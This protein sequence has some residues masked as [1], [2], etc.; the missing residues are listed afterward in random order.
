[1]NFNIIAEKYE[2]ISSIQTNASG[3]LFNLL[4][5]KASESVLDVGCGPGNLT[6]KIN[7]ITGVKVMGI[8]PSASMIEEAKKAA[9]GKDIFFEIKTAEDMDY[10]NQFDVIFCNSAF[11]WFKKPDNALKKFYTA[12]KANGRAG[13]QAPARQD[14]CPNFVMAID[15]IKNNEKTKDV[16]THFKSPWTFYET[17]DDYKKMFE[18]AGFDVAFAKIK[19]ETSMNSPD[20]VYEIFSSGAIAGY[21]NPENYGINISNEYIKNFNDIIKCSFKDQSDKNGTVELKFNRIYL[22]ALKRGTA[23]NP[24]QFKRRKA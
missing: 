5:I 17:A 20:K 12:L 4:D 16:F 10:E 6:R 8:D 23:P 3:I 11:Q 19:T 15:E 24:R 1:M 2:K 18:E 21:L 7:E 9:N 22:I 13:I 14:Y